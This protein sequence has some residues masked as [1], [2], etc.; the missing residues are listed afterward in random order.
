MS[1]D[2]AV[3]LAAWLA[4]P[5]HVP[6]D[7]Q[8][9]VHDTVGLTVDAR[10]VQRLPACFLA[11]CRE[12]GSMAPRLDGLPAAPR[13]AAVMTGCAGLVGDGLSPDDRRILEQRPFVIRLDAAVEVQVDL[14]VHC[15]RSSAMGQ[16]PYHRWIAGISTS[17]VAIDCHALQHLTSILIGW[18]LQIA[19]SARPARTIVRRPRPQVATQIRQL[20]LDHLIIIES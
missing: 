6:A 14:P 17:T 20:R 5:T 11:V 1:A 7:A 18:S 15:D 3:E 12:A 2:P 10:Q 16:P 13:L 9:L 4:G 19:Q 8:R